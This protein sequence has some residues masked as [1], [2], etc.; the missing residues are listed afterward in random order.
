MSGATKGISQNV[1]QKTPFAYA[2]H[3]K[4]PQK[5]SGLFAVHRVHD[6][7]QHPRAPRRQRG[8][9]QPAA[10]A[11]FAPHLQPAAA[12]AAEPDAKCCS[13]A[14]PDSWAP[15]AAA[16]PAATAPC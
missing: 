5:L 1:L 10:A 8:R 3:A 12:A 11:S 16:Q 7:L 4:A 15:A 6:A 13:T 9:P 2:R 14:E